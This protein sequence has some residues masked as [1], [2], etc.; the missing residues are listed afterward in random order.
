MSRKTSQFLSRFCALL[1]IGSVWTGVLAPGV[2]A[3]SRTDIQQAA[4]QEGLA[5]DVQ[6]YLNGVLEDALLRAATVAFSQQAQTQILRS[7]KERVPLTLASS[8]V[9]ESEA[10]SAKPSIM[11]QL[12]LD[13]AMTDPAPD[14]F[15][16]HRTRAP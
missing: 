5:S 1:L 9:L 16:I 3:M 6:D 15:G 13:S 2:V 10:Q 8:G 4:G 12:M 11:S 7:L 14:S